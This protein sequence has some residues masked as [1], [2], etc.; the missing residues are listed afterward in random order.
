V[1]GSYP[2]AQEYESHKASPLVPNGYLVYKQDNWAA[3]GAVNIL[4][5]G[6]S[7]SY[8]NG[9]P[10][11]N[12]GIRLAAIMG[13]YSATLPTFLNG[14]NVN[15]SISADVKSMGLAPSIGGS[16]KFNDMISASITARYI[17][18]TKNSKATFVRAGS[19]G[20]KTTLLDVDQTA[21]GIPGSLVQI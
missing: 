9:L 11:L 21:D 8:A 4:C 12:E 3:F 10:T 18:M 14:T 16:Y 20:T 2:G 1:E 19:T 17:S 6:G 13:A 15:G 5:G 7:L